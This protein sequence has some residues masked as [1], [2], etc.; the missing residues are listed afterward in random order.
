MK[1]IM[2]FTIIILAFFACDDKPEEEKEILR[3][4]ITEINTNK[5]ILIY[6]LGV[7]DDKAIAAFNRITDPKTH[8]QGGTGY[9]A[10]NS[11]QKTAVVGKIQKIVIVSGTSVSCT[12]DGVVSI[13]ADC[14]YWWGDII[15]EFI[16]PKVNGA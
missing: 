12:P 6:S 3:G 5:Q 13:G 7:P 8:E 4:H 14:T 2:I 16:Q 1:K 15:T 11:T 9:V 10:A